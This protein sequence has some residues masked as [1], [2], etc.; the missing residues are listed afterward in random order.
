MR[1]NKLQS[2]GQMRNVSR[3]VSR[4]CCLVCAARQTE[5]YHFQLEYHSVSGLNISLKKR[6]RGPVPINFNLPSLCISLTY[7]EVSRCI[8]AP[9]QSHLM[10]AG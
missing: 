5:I 1:S 6:I 3:V 4:G 9:Q 2:A 10:H 7:T 8:H